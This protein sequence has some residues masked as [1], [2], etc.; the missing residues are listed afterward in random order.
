MTVSVEEAETMG[1]L[2]RE[3]AKSAVLRQYRY[4]M[5]RRATEWEKAAA[6]AKLASEDGAIELAG[7]VGPGMRILFP[8]G[9]EDWAGVI[10]VLTRDGQLSIHAEDGDGRPQYLNFFGPT[11]PVVVKA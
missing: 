3:L 6:D 11:S 4:E 8:R 1:K 2:L 7:A 9:D 10:R 5:N